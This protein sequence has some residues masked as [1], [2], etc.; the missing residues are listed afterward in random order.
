MTNREKLL[1]TLTI[2]ELYHVFC[3]RNY[4]RNLGCLNCPI[5]N[6]SR[7]CI[8]VMGNASDTFYEWLNMEAEE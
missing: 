4:D 6:P 5:Y 8:N 2:G 7:S 1:P 3:N